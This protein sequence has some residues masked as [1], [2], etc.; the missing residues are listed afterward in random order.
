VWPPTRCRGQASCAP[1]EFSGQAGL[2]RRKTLAR[3]T[4]PYGN[5]R[6]GMRR[7]YG[8]DQLKRRGESG[9]AS[10]SNLRSQP[11]PGTPYRRSRGACASPPR[12]GRAGRDGSGCRC[13]PAPRNLYTSRRPGESVACLRGWPTGLP[14]PRC[15]AVPS[16]RPSPSP[17]ADRTSKRSKQT[18]RRSRTNISIK[19]L[20]LSTQ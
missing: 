12:S 7:P 17:N 6:A 13:G 9:K 20:R 15:S 1:W 18:D 3:R 2:G 19:F 5:R 11:S 8:A 4:R 14:A 10:W 16:A